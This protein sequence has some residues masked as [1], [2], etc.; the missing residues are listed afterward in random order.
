MAI[1]Q[2]PGPGLDYQ[3]APVTGDMA[4]PPAPAVPSDE[5]HPDADLQAVAIPGSNESL[6][7]SLGA[8]TPLDEAIS[9]T[10]G[11]P[12]TAD[13]AC[14][15]I[16]KDTD[17]IYRYWNHK[18]PDNDEAEARPLAAGVFVNSTTRQLENTQRSTEGFGSWCSNVIVSNGY[19]E[20]MTIVSW[21]PILVFIV[22]AFL[23]LAVRRFSR[24]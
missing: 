13:P 22:G 7:E 16:A 18:A 8:A 11:N 3:T 15:V 24:P 2:L 6:V 17:D 19:L 21:S 5:L 1:S 10:V 14:R 4:Q 20:P 23:F 12:G 9:S